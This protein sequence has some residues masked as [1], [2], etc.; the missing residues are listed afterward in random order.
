MCAFHRYVLGV[1]GLS[2]LVLH[3]AG[4]NDE[5]KSPLT[6]NR[7][8]FLYVRYQAKYY[9]WNIVFLLRRLLFCALSVFVSH[10]PMLQVFFAAI[11]CILSMLVQYYFQP[12]LKSEYNTFDN[13]CTFVI[14]MYLISAFMFQSMADSASETVLR[15][16][17]QGLLFLCTFATLGWMLCL[18]YFETIESS[19]KKIH[20]TGG[21]KRGL[22]SD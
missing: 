15:N 18:F 21:V 19:A 13:M 8:G 7:F 16:L 4:R 12:F 9:N 10:E 3:S 6:L 22:D 17:I 1:P 5:L 20:S 11:V 14:L 2:F